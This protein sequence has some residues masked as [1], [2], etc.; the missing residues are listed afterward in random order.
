[1][2]QLLIT[3]TFIV[4]VFL[5]LIAQPPKHPNFASTNKEYFSFTNIENLEPIE[6]YYDETFTMQGKNPYRTFPP[7][8]SHDKFIIRKHSSGKFI[9]LYGDNENEYSENAW[10]ERVGNTNIYNYFHHY[11]KSGII[12]T[13]RFVLSSPYYF[14]INE[15]VPDRQ[16]RYDQGSNYYAGLECHLTSTFIKTYPT[17][18]LYRRANQEKQE[19]KNEPNEWTGTGFAIGTGYLVTNYHVVENAKSIK[20]QGVKGYF[21]ASLN[22]SVVS[23]DKK[24]DL[25]IIKINDSQFNGFGTIPYKVKTTISDVGE[26]IFVLGYPL[27]TTM[28]DEIKL[29]TGVISSKTGFQGDMSLYQVSAPVQP[30]NSGGPLFDSKGNVIG[31]VSA[32]HVGAENVGYA[33]KATYLNN[34]IESSIG[35]TL[36][37]NNTISVLSLSEKVKRVKNFV[38]LITCTSDGSGNSV[39]SGVVSASGSAS[40]KTISFP[41]A[42][43]TTAKSA[44]INKVILTKDYTAVEI[45]DTGLSTFSINKYTYLMVDNN[46]YSM[47]RAEGIKISPDKSTSM[48]SG[49]TF[50]LYFQPIPLNATSMDLIETQQ[51]E[52]KWY[53]ISLR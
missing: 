8:T 16:I 32:K 49:I 44:R 4:G 12:N 22:A 23:T 21:G 35:I 3:I 20:I 13:V 9:L 29:T 7:E 31:I 41:S 51:S 42:K 14:E 18:D 24:N 53:G 36:P 6:G 28:G 30:G 46:T 37:A 19:I 10:I 11:G 45:T 48:Q 40:G 26:D 38:F 39:N 33:I 5:H 15:S 1:M 34:L 52:W 2:K 27:T 17:E 43:K 25:A 47:T 50:T